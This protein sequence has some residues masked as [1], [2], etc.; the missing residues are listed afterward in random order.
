MEGTCISRGW[1]GGGRRGGEEKE[2]P[3]I[4]W[5]GPCTR[6]GWG[7]GGKWAGEGEG[8]KRRYQGLSEG[9]LAQEGDGVRVGSGRGREW[10][11]G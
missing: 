10:E 4:Q 3:G 5:R 8:E 2:M 6:G 7:E 9:D 1:G 11:R